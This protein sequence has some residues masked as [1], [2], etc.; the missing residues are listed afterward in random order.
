[1]ATRGAGE[2]RRTLRGSGRPRLI[3]P[4]TVYF[5]S[6]LRGLLP[7]RVFDWVA[8]LSLTQALR[9]SSLVKS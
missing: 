6:A 2:M 9:P 5:S 7:L 3:L 4:W 8:R 1:M